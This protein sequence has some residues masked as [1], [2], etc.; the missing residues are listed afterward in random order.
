MYP[1]KVAFSCSSAA[2]FGSLDIPPP[3]G[4]QRTPASVKR[5][6]ERLAARPLQGL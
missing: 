5:A 2:L 1:L 3:R 6:T 4:E